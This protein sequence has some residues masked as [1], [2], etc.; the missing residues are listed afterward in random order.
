MLAV[1]EDSMFYPWNICLMTW[2]LKHF[3]LPAEGEVNAHSCGFLLSFLTMTYKFPSLSFS[4]LSN[5]P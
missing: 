3:S 5:P 4:V 2:I 1:T